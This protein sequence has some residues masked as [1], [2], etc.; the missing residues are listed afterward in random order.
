M[1]RG[2]LREG[3]EW[4]ERALSAGDAPPALRAKTTISLA[5]ITFFRGDFVR[6]QALVDE[7]AAFGRATG[8]LSMVAFSHGIGALAALELGDIS[9]CARLA[10]EAQAAARESTTPWVEAMP[11]SCLAY[12]AMHEGDLDRAGRIH[13]E[14]LSWSRRQGEK[15][16]IG[17]TLLDLALLRVVQ[18]RHAEAR[19]LCAEAIALNQEFGDRLGIAWCLGILSA[20]D[21]AEGQAPRAARLRG[22]MEGLLESVGAPPQNSYHTWIGDRSLELMKQR[23]DAGGLEAAMA[24]GRSLS[25]ARAIELGLEDTTVA[26]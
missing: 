18:Q 13:E 19:A 11:L 25:L 21:A 6:T 17:I 23:L 4:L 12:L 15:W 22:A 10:A 20:A 8:D 7:S 26:S 14:A 1:K 24:E 5:F 9:R 2:Y 3:Q 16:G